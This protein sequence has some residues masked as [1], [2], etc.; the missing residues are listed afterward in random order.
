MTAFEVFLLICGFIALYVIGA[1]WA[2][3][4]IYTLFDSDPK[5]GM[6]ETNFSSMAGAILWPIVI[7]CMFAIHKLRIVHSWGQRK[8]ERYVAMEERRLENEKKIREMEQKMRREQAQAEKD[9]D[10]EINDGRL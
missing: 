4:H 6:D 5:C 9:L 2:H 7:P 10:I 8:S 1:V 3:G